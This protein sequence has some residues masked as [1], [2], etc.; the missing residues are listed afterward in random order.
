MLQS[1]LVTE[2]VHAQAISVFTQR[3]LKVVQFDFFQVLLPYHSPPPFL[4]L[5]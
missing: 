4:L 5:Q 3:V 1:Y 2:V